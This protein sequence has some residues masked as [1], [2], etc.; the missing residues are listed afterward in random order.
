MVNVYFVRFKHVSVNSC[1][2]IAD[3]TNLGNL[4]KFDFSGRRKRKCPDSNLQ[5][6]SDDLPRCS[7]SVG[8]TASSHPC[9]CQSSFIP[10]SL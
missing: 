10:V 1:R 9:C 4:H 3:L 5:Q 2:Y 8:S 7:T 6:N